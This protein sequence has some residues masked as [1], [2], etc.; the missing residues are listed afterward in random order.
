MHEVGDAANSVCSA[1]DS[2]IIKAAAES[3]II[4]R[5]HG[6]VRSKA[7]ECWPVPEDGIGWRKY[8][9]N[10]SNRLP[11]GRVLYA[12]NIVANP[13]ANRRVLDVFDIVANPIRSSSE[14]VEDTL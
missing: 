11:N 4:F 6:C 3:V 7:K 12:L 8:L 9:S 5:R 13:L 10:L 1:V 14:S 2:S